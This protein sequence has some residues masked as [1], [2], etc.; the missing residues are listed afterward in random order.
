MKEFNVK[1]C[2]RVRY[3]SAI[4]P[5][6]LA[7]ACAA[8]LLRADGNALNYLL[9]V[10]IVAAVAYCAYMSPLKVIA[11]DEKI[12]IKKIIGSKSIRFEKI[13]NM[14]LFPA[15]G[16]RSMGMGSC[17]FL[18]Y[19]G[20]RYSPQIGQYASFVGSYDQT[21]LIETGGGMKYLISCEHPEELVKHYHTLISMP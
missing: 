13:E 15:T 6:V 12:T 2:K 16:M 8:L 4:A 17:G 19:T 20:L 7:G 14:A 9:A 21:I 3:I 10:C 5:V 1:W 11:D 18:G